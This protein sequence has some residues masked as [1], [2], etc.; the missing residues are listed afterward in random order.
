MLTLQGACCLNAYDLG[1]WET[2]SQEFKAE[3][4]A[5]YQK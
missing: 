5:V 2:L 3:R 4:P 1:V